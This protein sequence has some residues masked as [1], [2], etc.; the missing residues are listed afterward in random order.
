[1]HLFCQALELQASHT[2]ARPV[3]MSSVRLCCLMCFLI[4]TELAHTAVNLGWIWKWQ[5]PDWTSMWVNAARSGRRLWKGARG[6]W[7]RLVRG[8][9]VWGEEHVRQN[10]PERAPSCWNQQNEFCKTAN[11]K[12]LYLNNVLDFQFYVWCL[13]YF[14]QAAQPLH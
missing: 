5:T 3:Y 10:G 13:R 14:Q 8:K 7:W 11:P 4:V 12:I 1:M 6:W 9:G 2:L